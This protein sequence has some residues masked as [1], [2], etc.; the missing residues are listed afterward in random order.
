M[1]DPINPAHY[2]DHYPV[3]VIQLTSHMDFCRGN[4]V[5]YLARAG[6]KNPDT[7]LEDLRKAR[8]YVD[9]AISMLE[10]EMQF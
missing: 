6:L 8:W 4:A 10:A 7:E 9:Y 3:E 2:K 1:T 5:K